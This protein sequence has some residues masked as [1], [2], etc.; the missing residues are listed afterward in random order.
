MHTVGE[1]RTIREWLPRRQSPSHLKPGDM[2][3]CI[4]VK[5]GQRYVASRTLGLVIEAKGEQFV[6]VLTCG[7]L[8]LADT[9]GG[10]INGEPGYWTREVNEAT[11]PG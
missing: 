10:A 6:L 2:I 7:R 8:M 9:L 4:V 3:T 5:S 1:K 11:W